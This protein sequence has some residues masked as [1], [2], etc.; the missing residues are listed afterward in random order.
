VR[1]I[2]E[3]ANRIRSDN[4]SERIAVADVKDEIGAISRGSSTRCSTG[5]KRPSARIRRFAAE[6]SHE[7]KTPLSLVRLH[8]EKLIIDGRPDPLAAR[9]GTGAA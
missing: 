4:L 8:A 9:S 7:L 2:R 1:L 3:T 5:W 6:A